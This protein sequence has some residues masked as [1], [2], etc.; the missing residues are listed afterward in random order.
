MAYEQN[1]GH[2]EAGVVVSCSLC[3][4]PFAMQTVQCLRCNL[5]L[6]P[7]FCGCQGWHLL[8]HRNQ[9]TEHTY[10]HSTQPR[11]VQQLGFTCRQSACGAVAVRDTYAARASHMT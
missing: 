2:Q 8:G 4:L 1:G 11:M 5:R 9:V 3:G 10:Q 6:L 7:G